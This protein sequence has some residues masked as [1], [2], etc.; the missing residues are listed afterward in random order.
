MTEQKE[1]GALKSLKTNQRTANP[2]TKANQS[3]GETMLS[4]N[5]QN[6]SKESKPMTKQEVFLTTLINVGKAGLN[7]FQANDIYGDTCLHSEIST[8][9]GDHGIIANRKWET[10][11]NP[12]KTRCMR[13][14]L[15]DDD[16]PMAKKLV[17]HWRVLRGEKP[18]Y[19]V[20]ENA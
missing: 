5:T 9:G 11:T 3:K 1:K 13:Y 17:N 12:H 8:L 18:L 2:K 10:L 4:K 14:W 16:M 19:E 6:V 20:T 15:S 7:T